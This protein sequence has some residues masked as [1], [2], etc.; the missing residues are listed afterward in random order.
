MIRYGTHAVVESKP[1]TRNR[2]GIPQ[3]MADSSSVRELVARLGGWW[4]DLERG[5]RAVL[6]AYLVVALVVL[7]P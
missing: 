6:I 2:A 4:L 5:W 3:R 7:A 1:L